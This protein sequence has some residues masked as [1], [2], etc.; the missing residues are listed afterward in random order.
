MNMSKLK[1]SSVNLIN[2]VLVANL[3]VFLMIM[4]FIFLFMIVKIDPILNL[5]F[6]NN[7]KYNLITTHHIFASDN[8]QVNDVVCADK[9]GIDLCITKINTMTKSQIVRLKKLTKLR[10]KITKE[11]QTLLDF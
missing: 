8:F 9:S 4:S 2:I 10:E 3:F 7:P 1:F 5:Y 6:F 11:S